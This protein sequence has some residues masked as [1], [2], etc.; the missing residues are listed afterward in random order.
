MVKDEKNANG[1]RAI[2]AFYMLSNVEDMIRA[3]FYDK[4]RDHGEM[5]IDVFGLLQAL[6]VGVD[7]LYDLSI[8][9]TSFKYHINV[10]QNK[11]LHSLKFIRNDIVGHPTHRTY[12]QG[13]QGFS[14]LDLSR[15]S[16]EKIYYNTYIYKKNKLEINET[17]VKFSDLTHN[18]L[19][20]RDKL[21]TDLVKYLALPTKKT[22]LPEKVYRLFET[23]NVDLLISLKNSFCEKYQLEETCNHRFLWRA[24]LLNV[25]LDWYHDNPDLN[26]LIT[27]MAKV[28]VSKM[29]KIALDLENRSGENMHIAIPQ[30]L[31]GFYRFIRQNEKKALP[32]LQNLH[33]KSHPLFETD[34]YD[35]KQLQ[36]SKWSKLLLDWLGEVNDEAKVYLIGSILRAYRPKR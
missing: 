5:L 24:S 2:A 20:E 15:L 9:L 10:N 17:E 4:E 18:Y 33:D 34:L 14:I 16:K 26:Q 35:L 19:T 27:Y 25:C 3:F 13:G 36:Q 29:Y 23:L 6:F 1:T 12:S 11:V 7:A 31:S 28:Q 21:I 32:C 22:E 8:G 30:A